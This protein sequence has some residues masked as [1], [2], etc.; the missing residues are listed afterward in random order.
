MW[1]VVL[2]VV[3]SVTVAVL[4]KIARSRSLHVQQIVLWNY[5]VT[6]LLTYF[7]LQPNLTDVPWVKLPY[8][9]Y[10]PLAVLL[11]TLFIF[12][13]LAIKYSGIVKTDVAQRMSLFIPLLASFLLF[14]EQASFGT[15]IGIGVG[16]L[17]VV[18]SVSWNKGGDG[19]KSNG[20]L[21]P[22]VVFLGMGIIDVLFKQVAQHKEVS[23]IDSMFF[24]FVGAMLV[25]FSI[26][27]FQKWKNG[28][29]TSKT[30]V[31]WG[32]LLGLFNFLN[33]FFYMKAHR[34]IPDNPSIVFTT[35]NVGVIVVGTMIGVLVFK[36]KLSLV[37]KIGLV[38]AV[39]SILLIKYL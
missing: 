21:Y 16:L 2:S 29:G 12:I 38:L 3:C 6:V 14:N 18:F 39:I 20:I 11:P 22:S 30:T 23:Y 26:L 19:Q 34:A 37:N 9:L 28:E 10:I 33:I 15:L 32:S 24:V 8:Q 25:A 36:E 5:P 13:A 17:A 7:L 1:Y 31:L 35:M 27:L 4:L